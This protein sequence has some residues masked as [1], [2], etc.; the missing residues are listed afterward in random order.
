MPFPEY[1]VICRFNRTI[2]WKKT[3][4]KFKARELLLGTGEYLD[5][6]KTKLEIAEHFAKHIQRD[7]LVRNT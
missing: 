1:A 4:I 5:R 2:F 3:T 7:V 6:G